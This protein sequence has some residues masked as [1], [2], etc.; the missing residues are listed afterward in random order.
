MFKK[1]SII[2]II[3]SCIIILSFSY[4]KTLNTETTVNVV[5][6]SKKEGFSNC[7]KCSN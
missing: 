4:Y 1:K 7:S 6:I 3:I 5:P 2:L